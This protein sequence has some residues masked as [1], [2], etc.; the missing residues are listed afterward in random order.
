MTL[1]EWMNSVIS[2]FP[3]R[4]QQHLRSEYRAHYQDHLAAGGSDDALAL[5]GD[6]VETKRQLNKIYLTQEA[7]EGRPNLMYLMAFSLLGMYLN[8]AHTYFRF[9]QH[10]HL[11]SLCGLVLVPICVTW[12]WKHTWHW[13]PSRQRPFRSLGLMTLSIVLVMFNPVNSADLIL[14]QLQPWFF[15]AMVFMGIHTMLVADARVRRT[16]DPTGWNKA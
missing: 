1:D 2:D 9:P 10:A 11:W 13:D 5:F 16:L 12:L 8:D 3:R 6:P 14:L 4:V 7:L 15:L